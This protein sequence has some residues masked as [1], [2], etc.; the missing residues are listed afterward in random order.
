MVCVRNLP[1]LLQHRRHRTLQKSNVMLMP[2]IIPKLAPI[3]IITN[4]LLK[5]RD[6]DPNKL[7]S[8]ST[9]GC[10]ACVH[11]VCFLFLSIFS[12]PSLSST[13][14]IL[15][16]CRIFSPDVGIWTTIVSIYPPFRRFRRP[17]SPHFVA[18]PFCLYLHSHVSLCFALSILLIHH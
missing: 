13:C 8:S 14:K 7:S 1:R 18:K 10:S 12:V 15:P 16:S 2:A 17:P 9:H 11:I 5:T 3:P 4:R 6:G